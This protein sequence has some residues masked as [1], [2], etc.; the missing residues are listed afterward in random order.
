M[1][2]TRLILEKEGHIATVTLNRPESGNAFDFR[3]MEE[4]DH[5][6]RDNIAVDDKIRAVI[7]TG[8]GK[9][10]CTGVD[11]TIFAG[12]EPEVGQDEL[13]EGVASSR[14]GD[15]TEEVPWGKGT[16]VGAVAVIKSMGKPVIAAVNGPA[17][18]L[19]CSFAL[20]CDIRI[21]SDASRFSLMFVK[22]GLAPDTGG[23]FTLP[24]VVGWA[25]ASELL[26]TGDTID[27][28]EAERI[29]MVSK[30]VPHDQLMTAAREL[31]EKIARHPP[32]AVAA[33]KGA[34]NKSMVETDIIEQMK[35]EIDYQDKML[36]TEDFQEAAAAFLEKRE[37]VFK[38]R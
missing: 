16:V 29:G 38:G 33:T 37:A 10:F 2:Y 32:L 21:A 3:I 19:G 1:E 17:A 6:F 13:E 15:E 11:L 8:A 20:A 36:N 12:L 25:R 28:A 7:L 14:V 27:A 23:S 18:G 35:H 22:R 4:I 5:V 30:V 31:A 9:Y 26:L 34:L 24:R